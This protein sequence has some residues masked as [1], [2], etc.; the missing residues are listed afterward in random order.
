MG[1][2]KS[3]Q[4]PESF[5]CCVGTG[6]ESHSK[7]GRNI[8]YK[9]ENELYVSQF[10]AATVFWKERGVSMTQKTNFPQEHGTTIEIECEAPQKFTLYMRYPYWAEKGMVILINGKKIKV[11]QKPSS[12]VAIKRTWKSGDKIEARFPFTL[13]LEPMPD[14]EKAASSDATCS[15]TSPCTEIT[16][17]FMPLVHLHR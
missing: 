15:L 10:I 6:M 8:F 5:T 14:D 12:F 17:T 7:Y 4:D 9:N 3:Y 1:G 16:P 11:D 13:R 2:F